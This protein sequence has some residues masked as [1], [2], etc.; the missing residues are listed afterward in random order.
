[1]TGYSV[2]KILLNSKLFTFNPNLSV[3]E[4]SYIKNLSVGRLL[5]IY[6]RNFKP[7]FNLCPYYEPRMKIFIYL[8]LLLGL[9]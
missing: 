8:T 9:V 2:D 6:N 5:K 4:L 7:D 3:F 1:M